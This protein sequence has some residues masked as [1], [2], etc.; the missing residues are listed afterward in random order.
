MTKILVLVIL[1]LLLFVFHNFFSMRKICWR[2]LKILSVVGI[3]FIFIV[4]YW[5]IV[6]RCKTVCISNFHLEME[7]RFATFFM[8]RNLLKSL[9]CWLISQ[10]NCDLKT[11]ALTQLGYFLPVW[12]DL[13]GVLR[14]LFYQPRCLCIKFT[15]ILPPVQYKSFLLQLQKSVINFDMVLS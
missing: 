13:L 8:L 11:I 12:F 15:V 1:I 4:S 5:C 3:N 9:F 6:F 7:C 2:N 10:H 14:G